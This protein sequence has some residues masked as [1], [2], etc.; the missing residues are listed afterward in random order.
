MPECLDRKTP[1]ENPDQVPLAKTAGG[2]F[3]CRSAR[4][5]KVFPL[6]STVIWNTVNKSID[7][8]KYLKKG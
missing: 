4:C 6:G 3:A 8:H 5:G 7:L 1:G 2:T